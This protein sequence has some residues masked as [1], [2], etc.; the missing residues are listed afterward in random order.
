MLCGCVLMTVWDLRQRR[1][2]VRKLHGHT[3]KVE[4]LDLDSGKGTVVSGSR[5]KT[6]RLW[7]L[8]T[9]RTRAIMKGH[10]GGVHSLVGD[11]VGGVISAGRDA[12]VKMWD[13]DGRCERTMRGHRGKVNVVQV[14]FIFHANV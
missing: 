12:T 1:A 8:R 10:L 9:G 11:G 5:D 4:S 2:L 3:D 14:C 6:V 7:D 13:S